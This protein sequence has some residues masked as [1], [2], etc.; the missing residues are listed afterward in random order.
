MHVIDIIKKH[1]GKENAVTREALVTLTG[2]NDSS[3]RL[4]IEEA[5]ESGIVICSTH[6]SKGYYT[7][8]DETEFS[9]YIKNYSGPGLRRLEIASKQKEAFYSKDQ[10]KM[11]A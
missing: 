11:E 10:I 1:I 2:M 4:Q 5:R 9:E 7:P 8:K 3:V 6:K